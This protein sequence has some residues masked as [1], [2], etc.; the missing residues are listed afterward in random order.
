MNTAIDMAWNNRASM[1]CTMTPESIKSSITKAIDL[2][3][4]SQDHR[5]Q[6][7]T[8]VAP[9]HLDNVGLLMTSTGYACVLPDMAYP[10]GLGLA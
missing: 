7:A 8:S 10:S 3:L 6:T 2:A 1:D 4:D 9:M 5:L